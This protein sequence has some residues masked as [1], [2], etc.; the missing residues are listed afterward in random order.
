MGGRGREADLRGREKEDGKV[1]ARSGMGGGKRQ[2]RGPG[3]QENEWNG[4]GVVGTSGNSWRPGIVD[5]SRS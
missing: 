1:G 5:A 3:G 4:E 2:E